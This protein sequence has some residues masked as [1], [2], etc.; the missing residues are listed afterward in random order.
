MKI[1]NSMI[2]QQFL[3]NLNQ[4]QQSLSSNQNQITTGKTLNK[5]SDNPLAVAEDMSTRT[6]LDQ[7]NGYQATVQSGLTWMNTTNTVLTNMSSTLESLRNVVLQA[8]STTSQTPTVQMG[9][10]QNIAQLENNLFQMMDVKQG[11]SFLFGGY[12]TTSQVSQ[13]MSTSQLNTNLTSNSLTTPVIGQ[14]GTLTITGSSGSAQVSLSSGDTLAQV[15]SAIHA[16]AG[17]TGVDAQIQT[18]GSTSQLVFIPQNV[19]S[20][21]GINTQ[22]VTLS[23]GAALQATTFQTNTPPSK[24]DHSINY[25]VSSSVSKQIN[26]TATQIFNQ[27]PINGTANLQTTLQ[28]IMNDLSDPAALQ[29]DLGNLDANTSQLVNIQTGLGARIQQMNTLQ[30]QTS[31][32]V[33]ILQNQQASLEDANL[34]Q[35][36]TQYQNEMV[37]YQAALKVGS[38]LLLPTLAQYVQ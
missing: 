38:Q 5:P 32:M 29:K 3:Y 16:V 6:S 11:G 15:Q 20:A 34:A 30:T 25:Q 23:A 2:T 18:S 13:Y 19:G 27:T 10:G 8:L 21:I 37:T 4:L 14:G 7:A 35:L 1:T 9:L 12:A 26:V 33:N 24:A 28:N 22:G 36:T 31:N 17:Q